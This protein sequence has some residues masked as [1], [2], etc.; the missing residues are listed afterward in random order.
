MLL[1]CDRR[2]RIPATATVLP[3]LLLTLLAG[4]TSAA[5][6]APAGGP[7]AVAAA[8]PVQAPGCG[9]SAPDEDNG[10]HP[11]TPPRGASSYELLPALHDA[12]GGTGSWGQGQPV[13]DVSPERGAP[14]LA[15]DL[16]ILRV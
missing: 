8:N 10:A 13:P 5:T 16:S 3:A 6:A 1:S 15:V 9:K 2:R 7:V 11:T 12:H 4:S 14:P